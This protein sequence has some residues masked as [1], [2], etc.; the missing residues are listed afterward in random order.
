MGLNKMMSASEWQDLVNSGKVDVEKMSPLALELDKEYIDKVRLDILK[1]EV[2]ETGLFFNYQYSNSVLFDL[3]TYTKKDFDMATS[4][5]KEIRM[6]REKGNMSFLYQA[7][8]GNSSN[9]LDVIKGNMLR[10]KYA[11]FFKTFEVKYDEYGHKIKNN[12]GNDFF[13]NLDRYTVLMSFIFD[14]LK[15]KV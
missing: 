7:I 9:V 5:F 1:K 10:G 2:L 8:F 14:E 11:D 12:K 6:L 13:H 3:L 15:G 4:L